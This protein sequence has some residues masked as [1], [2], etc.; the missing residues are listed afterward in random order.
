M[1]GYKKSTNAPRYQACLIFDNY[2]YGC[3][4]GYECLPCAKYQ[5]FCN[6]ENV[7]NDNKGNGGL[8]T[9]RSGSI[10]KENSQRTRSWAFRHC[11]NRKE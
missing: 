8:R 10:K 3:V 5:G 4:S 7:D 2:Q 11:R 1:N 6:L 9:S